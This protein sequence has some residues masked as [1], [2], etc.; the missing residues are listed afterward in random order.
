VLPPDRRDR[1]IRT[2]RVM[3]L[4]TFEANL[5]IAVV[6][7]QARRGIAPDDRL[8]ASTPQLAIVPRAAAATDPRRPFRI[9]VI[10]AAILAL[11]LAVILMFL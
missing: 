11:E 7:D 5:V 10:A 1:L 9:A 3:G 8:A 2:G 6:Q 4:T